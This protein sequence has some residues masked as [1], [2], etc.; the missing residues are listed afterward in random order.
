MQRIY[1]YIYLDLFFACC[2]VA[3]VFVSP[4]AGTR[5]KTRGAE[6][7]SRTI[8]SPLTSR[9]GV[10]HDLPRTRCRCCRVSRTLDNFHNF[11]KHRFSPIGRLPLRAITRRSTATVSMAQR[12]NSR[13]IVRSIGK[14]LAG[15]SVEIDVGPTHRPTDVFPDRSA[16][17]RLKKNESRVDQ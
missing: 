11:S 2:S 7:K 8:V 13:I 5:W 10:N 16:S 14:S 17:T 6:G 3:G 15:S 1:I 12:T 4:I 9:P